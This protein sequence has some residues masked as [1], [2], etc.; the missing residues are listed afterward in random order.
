MLSFFK[1]ISIQNKTKKLVLLI[2]S[3]IN[4]FPVKL[5]LCCSQTPEDGFSCVDA[6]MIPC[7]LYHKLEFISS[8]IALYNVHSERIN[9]IKLCY[10]I[11]SEKKKKLIN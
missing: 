9:M 1:R 3:V 10:V 5:T 8:N 2:L 4:I 11:K 7:L 6:Q